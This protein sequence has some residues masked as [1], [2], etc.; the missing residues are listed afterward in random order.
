MSDF[1]KEIGQEK[2]SFYERTLILDFD[3]FKIYVEIIGLKLVLSNC[4][5]LKVIVW[6]DAFSTINYDT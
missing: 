1:S 3:L 5:V 2:N 4:K 6:K